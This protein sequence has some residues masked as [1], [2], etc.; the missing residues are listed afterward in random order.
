[1]IDRNKTSSDG[2]K[3]LRSVDLAI[4]LL[5]IHKDQAAINELIKDYDHFILS[6]VSKIKNA[7]IQ[8]E[9]DEAYSVAL[10]AF[11]EAIER[12]DIDKGPFLP[13]CKL[14][15]SSRVKNQLSQENKHHHLNLEDHANDLIDLDVSPISTD[16]SLEEEIQQFEKMLLH[17]DIPFSDLIDNAPKHQDTKRI[18][19][20]AAQK[21]FKS[22]DLMAFLHDK[23]RLPI[24][25]IAKRFFV[26]VKTLKSYKT[27]IIAILMILENDLVQIKDWIGFK[28]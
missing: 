13:F 27:Y 7:Y 28:K 19:I 11:V 26:S 16:L 6:V 10:M 22:E 2:D 8:I 1:M 25:E 3:D 21:T 24:T 5:D 17:Y 20:E 14:V 12:Y 18:V 4:S 23:R 9:N 15:I